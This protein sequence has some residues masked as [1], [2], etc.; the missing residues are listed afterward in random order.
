MGSE[1]YSSGTTEINS[2]NLI[3]TTNNSETNAGSLNPTIATPTVV[4][5]SKQT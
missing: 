3:P 5:A 2:S 1:F 4:A